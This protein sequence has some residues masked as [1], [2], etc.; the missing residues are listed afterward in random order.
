MFPFVFLMVRPHHLSI[1]YLILQ[2]KDNTPNLVW[3]VQINI[4]VDWNA[5]FTAIVNC[6]N[7]FTPK[8]ASLSK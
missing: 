4:K 6:T 5:R 1:E 8:G 3:Q 7:Q 2:L